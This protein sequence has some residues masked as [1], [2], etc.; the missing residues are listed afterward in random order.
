MKLIKKTKGVYTAGSLVKSYIF[1]D[2]LNLINSTSTI[3]GMIKTISE[4]KGWFSYSQKNYFQIENLSLFGAFSFM[5]E[6][7]SNPLNPK[8][9]NIGSL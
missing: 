8:F 1:L 2:D 9:N 5:Q 4:Q 3:V 6:I 7:D